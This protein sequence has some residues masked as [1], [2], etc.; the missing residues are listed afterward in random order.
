MYRLFKHL[1]LPTNR[2]LGN[3]QR[4]DSINTFFNINKKTFF[5]KTNFLNKKDF[6]SKENF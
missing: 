4:V 3:S 1:H 2:I 5:K 6:Y